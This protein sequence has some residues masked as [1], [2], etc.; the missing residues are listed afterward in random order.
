MGTIAARKAKEIMENTRDVLAMEILGSVQAIDLRGKKKLGVG[1]EAAYNLVRSHINFIEK[2]IVMYKEINKCA[3]MIKE[4]L[5]VEA[6]EKALQ[7]EL[8]L[9]EEIALIEG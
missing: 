4:N 9:N 2:D 1:T 5:I 3:Q 7:S 8:L 6:V